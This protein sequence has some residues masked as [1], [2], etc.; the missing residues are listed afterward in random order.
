MIKHIESVLSGEIVTNGSATVGRHDLGEF[1]GDLQ[2]RTPPPPFADELI[3]SGARNYVYIRHM[4]CHGEGGVLVPK[5]NMAQAT[6][7]EA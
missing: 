3:L 1:Q 7:M 4:P 6:Q 5:L 2:G